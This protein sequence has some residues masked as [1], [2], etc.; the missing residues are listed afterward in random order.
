MTKYTKYDFLILLTLI[1]LYNR[2]VKFHGKLIYSFYI[3]IIL[4][5]LNYKFIKYFIY[6]INLKK[7]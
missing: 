5:Y 7:S 4:I 3:N 1:I 6:I 2:F